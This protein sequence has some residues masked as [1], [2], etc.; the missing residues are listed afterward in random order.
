MKIRKDAVIESAA[1]QDETRFAISAPYLAGDVAVATD[2][3]M[4]AAVKVERDA[5]DSDGYLSP[6]ALA[7]G[8]KLWKSNNQA[9][10]ILAE[11]TIQPV[12]AGP[13]F[14]RGP[15]ATFPNWA[16][17]VPAAGRKELLIRFDPARLALLI[18]AVGTKKGGGVTIGVP[19]DA[20][21]AVLSGQ[22]L[23]VKTDAMRPGDVACLM[24]MRF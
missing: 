3:C 21:G 23:S 13:V 22:P 7:V 12:P 15:E 9:L 18:K 19:L 4:L 6:E 11:K 17:V 2:G 16:Q 10:F 1:S 8:R 24:P 14:P 5:E 20:N